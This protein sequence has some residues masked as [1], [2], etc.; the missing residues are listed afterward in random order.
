MSLSSV[1][2]PAGEALGRKGISGQCRWHLV[3]PAWL[4]SLSLQLWVS[5]VPSPSQGIMILP[6]GGCHW[7]EVSL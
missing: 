6:L 1:L 3:A 5:S 2:S 4:Q 7:A